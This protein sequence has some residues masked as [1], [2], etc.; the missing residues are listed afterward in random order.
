MDARIDRVSN[1]ENVAKND[2]RDGGDGGVLEVEFVAVAALRRFCLSSRI[3]GRECGDTLSSVD[4][5]L[6]LIGRIRVWLG[7][8]WG[9]RQ[10]IYGADPVKNVRGAAL[11]VIEGDQVAGRKARTTECKDHKN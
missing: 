7:R 3:T 9:A 11:G 8:D 10:Q 2:L 6:P 1:A 4:S 5:R